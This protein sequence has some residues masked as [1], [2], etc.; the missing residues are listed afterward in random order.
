MWGWIII[1]GRFR[2]RRPFSFRGVQVLLRVS[3][4]AAF[5]HQALQ[6]VRVLRG[7]ARPSLPLDW[8]LCWGEKQGALL[9]IFT[10]TAGP[11]G[12]CTKFCLPL[13]GRKCGRTSKRILQNDPPG[14]LYRPSCL[15]LPLFCG[16]CH[17]FNRVSLDFGGSK[18]DQ[19]GVSE[20]DANHVFEGVA[21]KVWQSVLLWKQMA[22]L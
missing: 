15:L 3:L 21:A 22:Q 16:V 13:P 8:K 1:W 6:I 10:H 2:I 9:S 7:D 4:G 17:S 20:L 12:E 5:A 18:F 19:L 14:D 11:I